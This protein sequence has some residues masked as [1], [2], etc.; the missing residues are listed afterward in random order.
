MKAAVYKEKQRLVVEE[1]P[2][3]SPGPGQV[4]IRVTQCAICGS[5]VHRFQ[6]G[7]LRPDAVMGHEYCGV[8]AELGEGVNEKKVGDRVVGGG[9]TPPEGGRVPQPRYTA[10]TL[11][12]QPGAGGAYAEYVVG[13]AWRFLPVPEGV[14]DDTAA[15]AEPCSVAV[16]AVR[17]SKLRL[18]D[19]VAVIGTGPI[20]LLCLQAARAS[21]ATTIYVSE[22]TEA[23]A[24]AARRMGADVVINPVE[25]DVVAEMVE[26]TDGQGPDVV[27][28]CAA[29]H[30]TLQQAL[31]MVRRDGQVVVVSLAWEEDPVLSVEWVGREV[32]MKT[33]YG[34][35]PVDWR[36]TLALM[37]RGA[38]NV[39]P[40]IGAESHVPLDNI[41]EAF[42]SLIRPGSAAAHLTV[43]P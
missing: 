39:E 4:L 26:L 23:R 37:E 5:D 31:E 28:E 21:G 22:P 41:Q 1:V 15:L 17:L 25:T 2:T 12:F 10:R 27:F 20:G 18:G 42:E 43:V 13:A 34:S 40:M 8:I 29:A 16:H 38:V 24:A 32:E 11:G 7:M 19:R 30:G 14:S 6:H 9:G 36:T 3:P 33:A 35:Q